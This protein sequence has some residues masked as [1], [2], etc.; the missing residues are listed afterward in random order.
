VRA[1]RA[2]EKE[3]DDLA[4]GLRDVAAVVAPVE[5]RRAD[6]AEEDLRREP[7]VDAPQATGAHLAPEGRRDRVEDLRAA[8]PHEQE[9]VPAALDSYVAPLP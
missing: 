3:R 7:R 6:H 1:A 4:R 2:L 9:N 5:D 8:L